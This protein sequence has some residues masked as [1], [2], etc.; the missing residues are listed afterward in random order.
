[1]NG[2]KTNDKFDFNVQFQNFEM[3]IDEFIIFQCCGRQILMTPGFD[4]M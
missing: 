2:N 3:I 4:K 1:M